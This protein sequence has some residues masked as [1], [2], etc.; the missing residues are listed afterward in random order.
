MVFLNLKCA[1]GIAAVVLTTFSSCKKEEDTAAKG[2]F[3]N[4]IF[5][6]NEGL[7]PSG[8]GTITY[9]QPDSN[10]VKQDIF[11]QV[12]H[13]PLGNIAQNMCI[14]NGMGYIVVNNAGTVEVVDIATFKSKATITNL[15]NPSQFL[16]IDESKA[17]I[18]DWVG[19]VAVADLKSNS[20]VK[21]I[22]VGVGPDAM[23]KLGN[24]VYVA[25]YGGFSIDST[26]TVIDFATD[27]VV[28]TI[29]VGDAPAGLVADNQGRVWVLSK[30]KGFAGYSQ[31]GDTEGRIVRINPNTLEVDQTFL[32]PSTN[33]HPEKP[34]VNEQK[35][36]M[37]F[38]NNNG[39]YR[40]NLTANHPI[41]E[42]FVANRSF[43]SLGFEDKTGLLYASDA[44]NF[45]SN[46]L[47]FRLKA[48][49]GTVVDSIP[50]GIVP[51]GFAFQ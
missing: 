36:M 40:F 48:D 46:G 19:N 33:D 18:S 22:A 23:L 14:Y 1:I 32:F 44:G 50:A 25:N 49:V 29:H 35:T 15:S 43:Y 2:A 28:K 45:I 38:L 13:R 9:F 27:K 7:F 16:V 12:N 8:T 17:Y 11:E 20:I 47:V 37:Y 3:S 39:I 21:N 34:V 30:G 10:I 31:P 42:L 26:V 24:Y 6:V 5:I 41:P 4:G 51:R